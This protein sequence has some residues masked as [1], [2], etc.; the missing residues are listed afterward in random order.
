MKRSS[1]S[2]EQGHLAGAQLKNGLRLKAGSE[3]RFFP[4]EQIQAAKIDDDSV[5][6]PYQ[7]KGDPN[8]ANAADIQFYE[9]G[10]LK[11]VIL[12]K[13]ATIDGYRCGPG[14]VTFF[15]SGKLQ[16]LTLGEDRVI[17]LHP[18]LDQSP[19]EK[20][21]KQGDRIKINEDGRIMGWGRTPHS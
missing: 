11:S 4:T 15:E 20:A 9:N 8:P 10:K 21:A 13:Q 5:V 3:L 19:A 17:K 7:V 16:E 2:R 6:G 14:I 1:A 18:Y 12:S